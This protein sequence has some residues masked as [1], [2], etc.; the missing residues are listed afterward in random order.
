MTAIEITWAVL[1]RLK[2]AAKAAKTTYP[3]LSHT[4][5]MDALAASE[6]GVRHFYELQQRYEA[7]VD[8]CV[9]KRGPVHRCRLC[10]LEFDGGEAQDQQLHRAQHQR[11]EEVSLV[12][13]YL[14]AQYAE[15]ERLK[16][17]GYEWMRSANAAQQREGALAILLSHF[18]RSLDAAISDNRWPDHPYFE[19]YVQAALAD[20]GFIPAS[21]RQRLIEEFGVREAVMALGSTYWP[22]GVVR[23]KAARPQVNLPTEA[24][25]KQRIELT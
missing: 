5:R 17:Q 10:G 20:A 13:N 21:I 18:D 19:E 4:Q 7:V 25:L 3:H 12:R 8:A 16:R 11:Y 1:A 15:R 6:F 9:D 14:P 22:A 2:K 23:G 24:L